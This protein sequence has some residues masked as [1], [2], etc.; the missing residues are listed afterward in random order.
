MPDLPF[1]EESIRSSVDR[2]VQCVIGLDLDE[3]GLAWKAP[4][5][6]GWCSVMTYTLL[7]VFERLGFGARWQI[8]NGT[9][10]SGPSHDWL[11]FVRDG[12]TLYSVDPTQHQF[13]FLG[14]EPF[15][16]D[17]VCPASL[18]FT[19]GVRRA[20]LERMPESWAMR[21]SLVV[22]DAVLSAWD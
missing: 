1:T 20:S 18:Q 22:R 19:L 3:L 6:A 21:D 5:P 10:P 2:T 7:Q 12:E 17:G 8:V 15:V 16:G 11:E 14:A 9:K 13:S 4:Y